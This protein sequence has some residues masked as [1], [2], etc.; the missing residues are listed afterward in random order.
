MFILA[1][2]SI[3]W[4][5]SFGWTSNPNR[6]CPS[7]YPRNDKYFNINMKWVRAKV[8]S[9]RPALSKQI[10]SWWAILFLNSFILISSLKTALCP[11]GFALF[12][13]ILKILLPPLEKGCL[14]KR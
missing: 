14:V 12:G 9:T 8:V 10:G 3:F 2:S 6:I 4:K 11:N 7:L 1:I 13:K 5:I